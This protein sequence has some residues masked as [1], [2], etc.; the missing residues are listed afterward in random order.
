LPKWALGLLGCGGVLGLL[1]VAL[2]VVAIVSNPSSKTSSGT[3]ENEEES[4]D[5]KKSSKSKNDS[6]SVEVGVGEP[7]ELQDRTLVVNEVERNFIPEGRI[8]GLEPGNEFVLLSLT[9]KNT[10]NNDINYNSHDFKVEDSNGVQH[11]Y[12]TRPMSKLPNRVGY[13][14]LSPGGE[15]VGNIAFQVPQGNNPLKLIYETDVISKRTIT[16]RL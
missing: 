11:N 15:L 12:D 7:G 4:E 9:L 1:L 14:E 13:G 8:S 16:V 2:L 6:K 3:Q 5:K 10:G